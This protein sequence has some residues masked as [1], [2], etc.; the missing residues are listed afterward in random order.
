[1][2]HSDVRLDYERSAEILRELRLSG[3]VQEDQLPYIAAELRAQAPRLASALASEQ[4][5]DRSLRAEKVIQRMRREARTVKKPAG[6]S[7]A[8]WR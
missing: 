3:R 8:R 2:A 4:A 1:M 7:E 5:S 6:C